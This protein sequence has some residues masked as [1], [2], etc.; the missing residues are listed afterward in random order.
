MANS[1]ILTNIVTREATIINQKAPVVD[2]KMK[3]E[4]NRKVRTNKDGY[5]CLFS[6]YLFKASEEDNSE[7]TYFVKYVLEAEFKGL[8]TD[9]PIESVHEA[10][11]QSLYPHI[12]AG[13]ASIMSAA[14]ME[15]ILLSSII[16]Q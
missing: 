11:T 3:L 8:L 15:A 14:G 6:T 1:L 2:E 13:I 10:I 4:I 16:P 9:A 5:S 12:R 7:K